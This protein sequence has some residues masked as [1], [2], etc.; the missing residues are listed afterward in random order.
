MHA[1]EREAWNA[2]AGKGRLESVCRKG[3]LGF[4]APETEA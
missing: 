2:C 3:T 1:P 4:R